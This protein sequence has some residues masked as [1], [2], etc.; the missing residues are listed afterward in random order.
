MWSEIGE[1][2][3][4]DATQ[5]IYH[6]SIITCM[7]ANAATCSPKVGQVFGGIFLSRE[8]AAKLALEK[9]KEL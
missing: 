4:V 1:R 7:A 3:A 2:L 5:E 8:K 9:L 6:C